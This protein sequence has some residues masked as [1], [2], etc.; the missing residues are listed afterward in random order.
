MIPF[1]FNLIEGGGITPE[2]PDGVHY[3]VWNASGT[4]I[5]EF[6]EIQLI[7]TYASREMIPTNP[8]FVNATF[9][10]FKPFWLVIAKRRPVTFPFLMTFKD[11]NLIAVDGEE[12]FK[13]LFPQRIEDYEKLDPQTKEKFFTFDEI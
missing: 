7:P 13:S 3:G 9:V 1:E 10:V 2:I 8:E 5:N 12:S 4:K 6:P 11:G